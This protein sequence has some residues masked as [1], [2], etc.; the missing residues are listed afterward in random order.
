MI[1]MMN[2]PVFRGYTAGCYFFGKL[3]AFG[4][5]KSNFN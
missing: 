3:F 1:N 5:T 2:H 4:N